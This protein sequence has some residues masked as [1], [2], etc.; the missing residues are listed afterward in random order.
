MNAPTL[1]LVDLDFGVGALLVGWRDPRRALADQ[2]PPDGWS[3]RGVRRA[4]GATLAG[5]ARE[6]NVAKSTVQSWETE[7][8]PCPPHV[9]GE[10][11]QA[12]QKAGE[13]RLASLVPGCVPA[14]PGVSVSSLGPA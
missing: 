4:H 2:Q 3:L 1:P 14:S 7:K 13:R 9:H 6:L 10:W 5:V 11:A 8:R 12:C